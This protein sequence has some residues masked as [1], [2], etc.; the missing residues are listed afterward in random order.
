MLNTGD[1]YLEKKDKRH[2]LSMVFIS[3]DQKLI[4]LKADYSN[5]NIFPF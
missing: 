2:C 5:N 1:E 3:L 4:L